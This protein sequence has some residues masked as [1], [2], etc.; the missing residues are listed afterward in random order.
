MTLLHASAMLQNLKKSIEVY[1]KPRIEAFCPAVDWDGL[2]G[3]PAG[4][5]EWIQPRLIVTG[6]QYHRQVGPSLWGESRSVLISVNIYARRTDPPQ[7]GRLYE[8]RDQAAAILGP[9]T[10]MDL[11]DFGQTPPV[12]AGRIKVEAVV[13]DRGVPAAASQPGQYN[14]TVRAVF[15]ACWQ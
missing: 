4:A 7:P 9:G 1:L 2:D 10:V 15:L 14:Y 6:G 3:P 8:L 12:P 11:T 5:Q 13:T